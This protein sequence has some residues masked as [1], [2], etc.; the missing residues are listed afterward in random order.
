[1]E[2][3]IGTALVAFIVFTTKSQREWMFNKRG[4]VQDAINDW[5]PNILPNE[6][7]Y[8]RDLKSHLSQTLAPHKI[9]TQ[10]GI[11]RTRADFAINEEILI[12]LKVDVN[13]PAKM[14]RLIGQIDN[15]KNASK[16]TFV[17]IC[18]ANDDDL[19]QSLDEKYD[20]DSEV[21]ILVKECASKE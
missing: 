10:F 5:K 8:E 14:H 4:L 6:K 16:H 13:S 15:Y 21:T 9:Q 1:M 19:I 2:W 3:L 7:A 11:G 12:E 20:D 17:V 18:G